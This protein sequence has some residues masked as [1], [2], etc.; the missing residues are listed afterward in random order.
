MLIRELGGRKHPS[1]GHAQGFNSGLI[2]NIQSS[3]HM[4]VGQYN[5]SVFNIRK[6]VMQKIRTK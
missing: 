3:V 2:S 1:I 5:L 6:L 4:F